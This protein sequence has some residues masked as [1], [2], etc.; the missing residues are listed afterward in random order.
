MITLSFDPGPNKLEVIA[1]IKN[2]LSISLREAKDAFDLQRV[3]CKPEEREKL[4]HAI[5]S[6]GGKVM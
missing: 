6:A 2:V 3:K 1:A 4:V 5:E